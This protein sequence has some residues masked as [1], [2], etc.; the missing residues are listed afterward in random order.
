MKFNIGDKV[1]CIKNSYRGE[2][3]LPK[4]EIL[5][6]VYSATIG[7]FIGGWLGHY[8]PERFVTEQQYRKL[9]LKKLNKISNKN[10]ESV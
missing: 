9:K 6:V 1:I 8:S 4:D 2:S 5:H 7:I 3:N 10:Y